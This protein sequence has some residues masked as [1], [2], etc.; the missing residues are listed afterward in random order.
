MIKLS[1]V[2]QMFHIACNDHRVLLGMS[3]HS[4]EIVKDWLFVCRKGNQIEQQQHIEEALNNGG[5]VLCE[6]SLL[7]KNVYTCEHIETKIQTLIELYY[8]N[9]C[10]NISVIGI[11]GTNGKTSVAS[12]ISQFLKMEKKEVMQLGTGFVKYKGNEE[13]TSNTTLGCFQLANYFRKANG[14]GIDAIVMEVS[15]HALDQNRINFITF[16]AIVYTNISQDHLDYHL[17]KTHY[18]YTKFKLRKY[19]KPKGFLVYNTDCPLLFDL[20]ALTKCSCIGVG[21][22]ASHFGISNVVL[23]AVHSSFEME[24]VVYKSGLLGMMNIYNIAQAIVLCRLLKIEAQHLQ[25]D[26][27]TIKPV[28]GRLEVIQAKNFVIWLDYAHTPEALKTLLQFANKV[29]KR[30]VICLIGCGGNRDHK[31]RKLMADIAS[32]ESDIAIY[33][34]DNSRNERACDILNEMMI[35][36]L[37]NVKVYENRYFAIKHTIK[38]AQNSDIIIIAGK[39]DEDGITIYG[40]TYPFSDRKIVR[41]RLV[42]EELAW[43]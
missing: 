43:K 27:L 26:C 37:A 21:L 14:N 40:K 6:G 19:V 8:G 32:E 5:V 15:S 41:E 3:D 9:L 17:T 11:T 23:D 29:K 12:I 39:G 7:C 30:R 13:T 35:S 28:L 24:K 20:P 18:Q 2:L 1:E 34:S 25:E 22:K 31:K 42:K 4:K 10:D 16:D 36:R 33:T 38:I